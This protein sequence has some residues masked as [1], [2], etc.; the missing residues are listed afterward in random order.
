MGF[1]PSLVAASEHAAPD[2]FVCTVCH[3]LVD[4][5]AVYTKC[6]HGARVA[7]TRCCEKKLLLELHLCAT[8]NCAPNSR[9]PPSQSSAPAA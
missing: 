8:P 1:D 4:I 9:E 5:S 6:T 7:A 3:Q 2:D